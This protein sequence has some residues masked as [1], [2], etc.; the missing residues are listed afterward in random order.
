MTREEGRLEATE[1][2]SSIHHKAAATILATS[3]LLVSRIILS[4]TPKSLRRANDP[5]SPVRRRSFPA[6]KQPAD[7]LVLPF[8]S[9]TRLNSRAIVRIYKLR[10]RFPSPNWRKTVLKMECTEWNEMQGEKKQSGRQYRF[11][12]REKIVQ[13]PSRV[14]YDG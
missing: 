10:R 6:E 14:A 2:F 5:S 8:S 4:S 11:C 12:K 1:F 9:P 3:F 7:C 13:P